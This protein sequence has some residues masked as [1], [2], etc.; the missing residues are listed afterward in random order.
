[1]EDLSDRIMRGQNE[2]LDHIND[3]IELEEELEEKIGRVSSLAVSYYN[4]LDAGAEGREISVSRDEVA[5]FKRYTK[6]TGDEI[7]KLYKPLASFR[8]KL[9]T[10]KQK[11]PLAGPPR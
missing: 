3:I 6:E 1:M 11:V 2:I 8:N 9:L 10:L 5:E 4:L 7:A